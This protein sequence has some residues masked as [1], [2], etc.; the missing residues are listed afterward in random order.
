MGILINS[1]FINHRT[2]GR[3]EIF[4][5]EEDYYIIEKYSWRIKCKKGSQNNYV[6]CNIWINGKR[7][8]RYL[9]QLILPNVKF[10]DHINRNSLDNRRENLREVTSTQNY[11]NAKK[12]S[13]KS[14]SKFKGVYWHK[15]VKKWY[16]HITI[17]YNQKHL[18]IFN[19]ELDAAKAYN[20]AAIE[21]FGEFA[22][23]NKLKGME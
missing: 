17:N 12:R 6:A 11:Q 16:A 10:V 22:V 14:T 5:S 4:F 18:G 2:K 23:L 15:I 21:Y 9:H 13:K 8:V 1:F 3:F 19:L 20:K 7:T